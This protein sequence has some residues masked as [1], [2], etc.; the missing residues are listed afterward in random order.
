MR[1]VMEFRING[2][3]GEKD[4]LKKQVGLMTVGIMPLCMDEVG[5]Q[6]YNQKR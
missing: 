2:A 5:E 4:E 6:G 1:L 3:V